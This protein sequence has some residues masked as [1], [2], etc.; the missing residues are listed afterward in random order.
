MPDRL[1]PEPSN[2]LKGIETVLLTDIRKFPTGPEPSNSLKGIETI[3]N[4]KH[5]IKYSSP[6]PSNSLKGIET[7]KSL[8]SVGGSLPG[9]NPQIP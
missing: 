2:S 1:R 3:D 5:G 4:L 9:R 7:A 8:C 6:E